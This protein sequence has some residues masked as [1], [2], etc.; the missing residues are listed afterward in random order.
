M[1]ERTCMQALRSVLHAVTSPSRASFDLNFDS[2]SGLEAY[3]IVLNETPT[4]SPF[5]FE[6]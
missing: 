4:P 3:K 5:C 6:R 1:L 2:V